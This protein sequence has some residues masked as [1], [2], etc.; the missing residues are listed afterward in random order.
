MP[1]KM[2]ILKLLLTALWYICIEGV[3]NKHEKNKTGD[4]L[5]FSPID[6]NEWREKKWKMQE[7]QF[8]TKCQKH[9]V[10]VWGGG[11]GVGVWGCGCVEVDVCLLLFLFV[12]LFFFCV[13][14]ISILNYSINELDIHW[15][16]SLV[17]LLSPVDT[18]CVISSR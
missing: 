14:Y 12:C 3:N 2:K 8:W 17:A 9:C 6:F 11:C 10:C 13:C 15:M 18:N 1:M 4:M 7:R 5:F 16:N